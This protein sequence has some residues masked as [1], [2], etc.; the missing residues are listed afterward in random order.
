MGYGW[1][2]TLALGWEEIRWAMGCHVGHGSDLE[3]KTLYN[4]RP[5]M[6]KMLEGKTGGYYL[7]KEKY[8]ITE[9]ISLR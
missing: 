1:L 6:R 4:Y 3:R 8:N 2:E 5:Q 9:Q 7:D